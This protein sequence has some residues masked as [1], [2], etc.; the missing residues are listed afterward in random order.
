[1]PPGRSLRRA[2][3]D[4]GFAPAQ[5]PVA[6]S[7]D[8]LAVILDDSEAPTIPLPHGEASKAATSESQERAIGAAI[9]GSRV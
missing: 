4:N 1:M 9:K 3:T 7:A 8:G 5:A 2:H 6:T